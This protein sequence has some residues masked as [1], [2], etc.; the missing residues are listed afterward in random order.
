MYVPGRCLWNNVR[1]R[2]MLRRD[3]IS[4]YVSPKSGYG[5]N[6]SILSLLISHD[7]IYD[8]TIHMR[9]ISCDVTY[10]TRSSTKTR[11]LV[12]IYCLLWL[13]VSA[14]FLAC[15][16]SGF[17]DVL[18]LTCPSVGHIIGPTVPANS[19][20]VP[21]GLGLLPERMFVIVSLPSIVLF[22][23]FSFFPCFFAFLTIST[24]FYVLLWTNKF[25]TLSSWRLRHLS[26]SLFIVDA[27]CLFRF[28]LLT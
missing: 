20:L 4:R 2:E 22:P 9:D 23:L 5:Y 28:L 14:L 13:F 19:N 15:L 24:F 25:P 6:I 8:I 10:H 3:V 21:S 12:A 1:S 27:T 16:L 17:L 7:T 11:H 18:L 26:L